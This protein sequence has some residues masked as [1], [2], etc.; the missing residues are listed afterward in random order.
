MPLET[1]WFP[2]S[3]DRNRNVVGDYL[4]LTMSKDSRIGQRFADG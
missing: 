3:C 2:F 4:G 1:P